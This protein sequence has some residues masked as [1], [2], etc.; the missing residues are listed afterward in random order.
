MPSKHAGLSTN[1]GSSIAYNEFPG[2]VCL[3][4]PK[5]M[6]ASGGGGDDDPPL[7]RSPPALQ[8]PW[9]HG[10]ASGFCGADA[11]AAPSKVDLSGGA[12]LPSSSRGRTRRSVAIDADQFSTT[13]TA[14]MK[15]FEGPLSCCCSWRRTYQ[16]DPHRQSYASLAQGLCCPISLSALTV[17]NAVATRSPTRDGAATLVEHARPSNLQRTGN[18]DMASYGTRWIARW[19]TE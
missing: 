9:W 3:R 5:G 16:P 1:F 19:C 15:G 17:S 18:N 8:L 14:T 12:A 10:L 2:F 13:A 4:I 11:A 7:P 6:A